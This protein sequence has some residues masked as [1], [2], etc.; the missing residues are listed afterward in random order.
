VMDEVGREW[1]GWP[2]LWQRRA[3]GADVVSRTRYARKA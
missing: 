3:V 2:P 1:F